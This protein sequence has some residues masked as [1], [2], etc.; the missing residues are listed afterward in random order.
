[1]SD[2]Q[3]QELAAALYE[4]VEVRE[5]AERERDEWKDEHWKRHHELQTCKKLGDKVVR[6]R[7]EAVAN[8]DAEY[9]LKVECGF[10]L[11]EADATIERV[12]ALV[13]RWRELA[14]GRVSGDDRDHRLLAVGD[15]HRADELEATLK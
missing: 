12:K 4:E 3:E 2:T 11:I 14:K 13:E 15:Q 1:M 8:Y 5:K 10:K 7:V 6:E 9:K